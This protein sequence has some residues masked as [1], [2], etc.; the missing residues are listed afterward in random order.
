M[1]LCMVQYNQYCVSNPYKYLK[2]RV[3]GGLYVR[4]HIASTVS[5]NSTRLGPV[6]SDTLTWAN[7]KLNLGLPIVAST[8]FQY[9][10]NCS[11]SVKDYHRHC[12]VM[13]LMMD[14]TQHHYYKPKCH[15]LEEYN[16][17]S[18]SSDANDIQGRGRRCW[19]EKNGGP[20]ENTRFPSVVAHLWCLRPHYMRRRQCPEG[21][22]A[23]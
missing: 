8:E 10:G 21:N 9:S 14:T 17:Q 1:L 15:Q 6:C 12:T 19:T 23:I 5:G 4:T 2:P 16:C 20:H 22:L 18:T 3:F 7:V 13:M 11:W